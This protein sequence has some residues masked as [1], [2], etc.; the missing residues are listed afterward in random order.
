MNLLEL[1]SGTVHADAACGLDYTLCG[2]SASNILNSKKDYADGKFIW[3]TETEPCMVYTNEKI[4]CEGCEQII[5]YCCKLG[6][7]SLKKKTDENRR[8]R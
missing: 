5:R 7:E 1:R 2:V 6:L 4:N 8:K 3:E